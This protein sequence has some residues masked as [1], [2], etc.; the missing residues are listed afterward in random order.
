MRKMPEPA[1]ADTTASSG[2][3]EA[4]AKLGGAWT[5]T[6]SGN[7]FA[8]YGG[9]QIPKIPVVLVHGLVVSSSYMVPTAQ[10]LASLCPV[11]ALDLPGYGKS[12]K[13][14]HTLT[15]V[16]LANALEGWLAAK[17]LNRV[18]L[19]GN[20]MGCQI[21]AQYALQYPGRIDRVVLQGPTVDR[22][23]RSFWPQ[24]WRQVLNSSHEE[25]GLGLAIAKDYLAAGMMRALATVREVLRDRI[26]DKLPGLDLPVLVI[27]GASDPV[28][29][30]EW[31]EEV[32]RLL[33][34]GELKVILG[35][36]CLNYSRP[37]ELV[38]G[39]RPFLGL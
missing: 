29:P 22:H 5:S 31:A 8:R 37:V 28:C 33:P 10:Q 26:E 20:S 27:R 7:I 32:V 35:G 18:H 3:V 34:R 25:P 15:I 12:F 11:F 19:V 2:I 14:D 16:Q 23:A 21:I 6:P 36:H 39:I 24:L 17:G 9:L 13:P 30:Q 1:T 38:H 4:A